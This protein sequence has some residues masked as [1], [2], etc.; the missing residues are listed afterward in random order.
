MSIYYFAPPVNFDPQFEIAVCF[1]ENGGEILFIQRQDHESSPNQWCLPGGGIH[2]NET[3]LECVTREIKEET[4]IDL[5]KGKVRFLRKMYLRHP[6]YSDYIINEFFARLDLRPAVKVNVEE[7]KDFKWVTP[8][9][10]LKLDLIRGGDEGLKI[11]IEK[12]WS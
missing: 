7:H 1:I 5:P 6:D 11:F 3:A 2:E 8:E 9:G 10:A 4:D 12:D